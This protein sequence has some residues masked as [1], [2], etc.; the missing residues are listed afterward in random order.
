MTRMTETP[1]TTYPGA[2]ELPV[3]RNLSAGQHP[4]EAGVGV[5]LQ[6]LDR[7]LWDNA[8]KQP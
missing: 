5:F 7:T 2:A 8:Y 6:A 3:G 1:D 4:A